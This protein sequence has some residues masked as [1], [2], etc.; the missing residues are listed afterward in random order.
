MALGPR[1]RRHHVYRR[2]VEEWRRKNAELDGLSRRC[3]DRRGHGAERRSPAM[4]VMDRVERGRS[5]GRS[6]I[7][8]TLLLPGAAR[9]RAA[10][11]SW[12]GAISAA[13]DGGG[14]AAPD[15]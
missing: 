5:R 1:L 8:P 12:H 9:D 11:V 3:G 10:R 14:V 6:A 15:P 7:F 13:R 2:S 4:A